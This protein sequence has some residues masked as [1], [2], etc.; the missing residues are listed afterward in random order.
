[1]IKSFIVFL[2]SVVGLCNSFVVTNNAFFRM[3]S[4]SSSTITP[5]PSTPVD[6]VVVLADAD[7]VGMFVNFEASSGLL[8]YHHIPTILK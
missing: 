2:S 1:M 7:A 6:N 8:T 4:L 3:V 5:P